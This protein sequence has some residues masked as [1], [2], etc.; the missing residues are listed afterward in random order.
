MDPDMDEA[1]RTKSIKHMPS[2]K[3]SF[4]CAL[5]LIAIGAGCMPQTEPTTKTDDF[6]PS[7]GA[8]KGPGELGPWVNRVMLAK[9]NDGVTFTSTSTVIGD[10]MDV[11][12]LV[13]HN[14]TLFLYAIAWTAGERK[15]ALIAAISEDEG[16]TWNY[17]YV[18]IQGLTQKGNGGG[19]S[20]ADPDVIALENGTLR[21]YFTYDAKTHY[22]DS[23]DG[24]TFTYGG[25]AFS[26]SNGQILDP[27]IVRINNVWHLYAGGGP[28]GNWH[29]TSNDGT[30]FTAS[31]SLPIRSTDGNE[32]ML[33][34][35]FSHNDTTR[36]FGFSNQGSDIHTFTSDD[37]ETFNQGGV[38]LTYSGRTV[39]ESSYVKDASV[40]A[41]PNGNCLMA[42]VTHIPE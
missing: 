22:A 17:K 11:P 31:D 33:S 40:I 28:N 6:T 23:E 10:Q 9:S 12:D 13:I 21:M 16:S 27:S 2:I 42:Y 14:D 32:Y 1:V 38:A 18:D 5:V 26:S 34:N 37:G 36:F 25:V 4:F 24:L 8:E 30:T 19:P 20:P 41:L 7:V 3:L 35:A 15:N 29:A 39:G